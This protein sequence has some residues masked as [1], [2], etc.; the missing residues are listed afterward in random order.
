MLAALLLPAGTLASQETDLEKLRQRLAAIQRDFDQASE[1]RSEVADALR[2]SERAISDSNRNLSQLARQRRNADRELDRLQQRSTALSN[3]YNKQQ[4]LLG[5]LLYR[6]YIGGIDQDYLKL[7]LNSK[8]P[9]QLARE[10][11]YYDYIARERAETLQNLRGGLAA[12]QTATRD[13]QAKRQEIAALQRSEKKELNQLERE[14]DKRRQTLRKIAQQLKKQQH[15][16]ERLRRNEARLTKLVGELGQLSTDGDGAA[17]NALKGR[18]A[19]PVS[20]KVSNRFGDRRAESNLPWTGWFVRAPARHPVL[21]I[22]P[23]RVVYADWL[24]GFGNLLIIDHGQGYMSLYG[25]NETL[26]KQVGES[27][28]TGDIVASVGNS[29]GNVDSGLYFELRYKGSPFNP[30]K[31]IKHPRGK[32]R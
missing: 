6:Q 26:Y 13:T 12:L 21:A 3:D 18:L 20:G 7:L 4:T 1:S 28:S 16:I 14:Q 15:E 22:A 29:G 10:L 8:E 9:N 25:N 5:R 11:R 32:S 17:F 24:R 19:L 30:D 2:D 23:G 27:I 31:W